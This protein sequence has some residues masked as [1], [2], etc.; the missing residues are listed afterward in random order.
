MVGKYC[1]SYE[2]NKMFRL[3]QNINDEYDNYGNNSKNFEL[4][5]ILCTKTSTEKEVKNRYQVNT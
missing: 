2:H 3:P 1:W 4:F 5:K